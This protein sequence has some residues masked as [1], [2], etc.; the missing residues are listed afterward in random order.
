MD[1]PDSPELVDSDN[2]GTEVRLTIPCPFTATAKAVLDTL[3]L[4]DVRARTSVGDGFVLEIPPGVPPNDTAE[5]VVLRGFGPIFLLLGQVADTMP[6]SPLEAAVVYETLQDVSKDLPF[7][8]W[9]DRFADGR[10]W[11]CTKA[12]AADVYLLPHLNMR[13]C[14]EKID[15][16]RYPLLKAYVSRKVEKVVASGARGCVIS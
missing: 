15:W 1:R 11:V 16:D 4:A 6:R 8:E 2:E 7:G 3:E 10:T 13:A 9:E 12:T 5:H 14:D